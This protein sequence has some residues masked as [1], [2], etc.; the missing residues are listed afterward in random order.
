MVDFTTM[1]GQRVTPYMKYQLTRLDADLRKL[2]GVGL[3][4]SS[5]I[6][7][8][9]EQIDIFLQRYVTAANI[10]GRRVY[11][12]RVWRGVRYYRISSAGTVAQ[13]GTS[14]HEI[15][16][17]NAAVDIRDTG[18]DAG[19]TVRN[20]KR[21]QWLRQ[22]ASKYGLVA[23]GDNFGEGW[24]FRVPNYNQAV[25]GKPASGGSS[26]PKGFDQKTQDRQRWLNKYRGEKLKDDGV[27]GDLTKAAYKRYQNFLKRYGYSGLID[28]LWGPRMQTA[29]AKYVKALNAAKPKPK[30]APKKSNPFGIPSA[31]GLQKVAKL[32]GY[33]GKIDDV[34]GKGSAAGFAA[35]LRKSYGY[36]GN[37][38]L[39][40]RMWAA[41]ARWLRA[42]YGYVGNDQPGPNM[43]AALRRANDKN[44]RELK[45]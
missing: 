19:I 5:G 2:F 31:E 37:D 30:P 33:T 27:F 6:R 7:L 24:H 36:Y 28:G 39:G 29:H 32:Y 1:N 16:G 42:R 15:Q 4:V 44:D 34:W 20:S 41:I 12:T 26:K 18:S 43:R 9:Q 10:R 14:N 23:E 35:F 40:P 11:D 45:G 17:T 3:V 38:V 22:N 8:A 13:P 21:G 25:P